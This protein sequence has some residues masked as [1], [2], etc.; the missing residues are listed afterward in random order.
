ML[1]TIIY[2]SKFRHA[3]APQYLRCGPDKGLFYFIFLASTVTPM[4]YRV[5]SIS[6]ENQSGPAA[7]EGLG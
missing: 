5:N 6:A 2:L 7:P 4:P 3:K 1:F